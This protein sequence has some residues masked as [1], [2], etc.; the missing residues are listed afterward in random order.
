EPQRPDMAPPADRPVNI[1]LVDDQPA[2]LLALEAILSDLGQNLVRALSGEEALRR[3][4][5]EDFAVVLL[6][7]QMYG[8]DGFGTARLI[9]GRERTRDTPIIFLTGYDTSQFPVVEAYKLG[10][11]DYLVKPLVPEILRA[12]VAVFVELFRKTERL[13]QMEREEFERHL[14]E[15]KR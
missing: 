7:V 14:A 3:L 6:D 15:E 13:R 9:R 8:L 10:A 5:D 12:K 11:V 1:L 2:N 4:R